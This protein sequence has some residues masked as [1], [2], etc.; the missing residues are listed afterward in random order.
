[1][2][3]ANGKIS[4][5]ATDLSNYLS[6][7]HLTQLNRKHANN[8]IER[9][10]RKNRFLDRIIDRGLEHEADYIKHLKADASV[11][12]VEFEY[13]EA[14]VKEKTLK[15]MQEGV[16]II[17]QGALANDCWS[18]RPDLLIKTN[19]PSPLLGEW[20]YEVAD[21]KL[22]KTTKAGTILQ[23]CVYSEMIT[24]IQNLAPEKM[25]VVMPDDL[26]TNPFQTETHRFDD[27]ASYFRMAKTQLQQDANSV[28]NT[29][30]EPVSHCDI[31][32]WW[33]DCDDRRRK[34][35]H[36][37]FVA[38]IQQSQIFE[39]KNQGITTLTALATSD[40]PIETPTENGSDESIHRV[41]KQAKI[42]YKGLQSE[43]PEFEFLDVVQPT[44]QDNQ[45][46]GF[47][48]LPAPDKADIFFDIESSRHA[49][50]GGLEYLLGY[51]H[52]D[53]D[54][55][56]FDYLWG[57]NRNDE[58]T[59]FEAFIDFVVKRLDAS[60][61]MHIYHFAPYEPAAMKRLATRHA[62]K[63][64]ELDHLLRKQCFVDLYSVTR[65]AIRASVESYSIKCLEPF[66]EFKREEKLIDAR[67]AMH[68][69]EALLERNACQYINEEHRQAILTY[70]RDDCVS[71]L[72]LRD[73]LETL[74]T[75]QLDSGI[76]LPR[77][78]VPEKN[79]PDSIKISEEVEVVYQ[80]LVEEITDTPTSERTQRQHTKWLL[81][82]CLD[83]FNRE[84]KNAWWEYF[85]LRELDEP[86]LLRE[87]T[88][89][90]GLEFVESIPDG[91]RLPVHRYRFTP[92]FV[93][94]D[95]GAELYEVTS[96]DRPP[97]ECIIGEV[98]AIDF[99]KLTIDIKKK[100][101]TLDNHPQAVFAYRSVVIDPLQTT[102]LE[103]GKT[104]A[105]LPDDEQGKTA[106]F[107]LLTRCPPRFKNKLNMDSVQKEH[108]NSLDIAYKLISNLKNSVL[109]IQGPPGTGKT[110]TGS[111]VI[112]KLAA[113]G[114][115]IG[116]TAVGHA[117]IAN[118]L[119][120]VTKASNDPITISHLGTE[121][122]ATAPG[123]EV[124]KSDSEKSNVKNALDNG[125]VVGATAWTWASSALT[126]K[127]DYL[128]IDEA[129]QMALATALT[130]ARAAKN[131]ILLG[132]PQQLEQ[133]Q[134]A[135]HP[136]G[137]EIAALAHLIGD[138]QTVTR[139]QGL[140][141]D[142]TY[143]MH[144]RICDF[145]SEQYYEGRLNSAPGLQNQLI[146]GPGTDG[147]QLVYQPVTHAGNQAQSDEE[148][149]YIQELVTDLL[150]K[151]HH[152][153]DNEK[154]SHP[155]QG[156]DILVVAP[157]NAQV[158]LLRR[159]LP[160]KVRVGTVDK[161]Q[162]Q[163]AP[164]VIYSMTSS[165]TADAPRGMPFLFSPNRFNV[166]TSRAKCSVIVVGSPDLIM[167]ECKTPEHIAWANG[168]CRFV[169]MAEDTNHRNMSAVSKDSTTQFK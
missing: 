106:Q 103:F 166:A 16:N 165:T 65:Q 127:L 107:D 31:C 47:L 158:S 9:P 121:A 21:T 108:S 83:Y 109:A 63:E 111:H 163:E 24:E 164:V 14:N 4:L 17:A 26:D 34:D 19:T 91:N 104:I 6:C 98:V 20:S 97:K 150:R 92:Q 159:L 69:I 151:P 95:N 138:H 117:V 43:R 134:R 128:F 11:S 167:A 44:E 89:I 112:A 153:N 143:R 86:E 137:S 60:P 64:L 15:A 77:P 154:T 28:I 110:Y 39:L 135:T 100:R 145:T 105:A 58:K 73:W 8:E 3:L 133:P 131:V 82:H 71:T 59:A 168:L 141:L 85:R 88:A 61:G 50:G 124:I 160:E 76:D 49:P 93:T 42:Q 155:L 27:Y 72:R 32:Q 62:T 101:A 12:V 57:L 30:P 169:E 84:R 46:R 125:W 116:I 2:K 22:T 122:Q 99:E 156:S 33:P 94:V 37:T 123:C 7:K 52:G 1:M 161:F 45:L 157:Y 51:V 48:K 96:D 53:P 18:G 5:S 129:G 80:N 102:L 10:E 23:L 81:A 162:G 74:R 35:D 87:R 114:K 118:L 38:G 146:S 13:K 148:A 140:F 142:T 136:E 115:R 90:A 139:D 132:D 55:P 120:S 40:N 68:E 25:Y 67:N 130:T 75:Q 126:E 70:N 29:Y 79:Q 66:Y 119:E 113:Q 41:H 54:Y 149:K 144:P 152:W 56:E 78:P 36:L 147:Y